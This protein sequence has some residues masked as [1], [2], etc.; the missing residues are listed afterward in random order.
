[1]FSENFDRELQKEI[2]TLAAKAYPNRIKESGMTGQI[3]AINKDKL[4]ANI[5]Y[6]CEHELLEGGF[7]RHQFKI[8]P[9]LPD[10]KLTQ[11][12]VDFILNDG[13]LPALQDTSLL[14]LPQDLSAGLAA[15][16]SNSVTD[17]EEK[18]GMLARLEALTG[19]QLT[20][21]SLTLLS[22]GLKQTPNAVQ[23][24]QSEFSDAVE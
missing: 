1:M 2:L 12:G 13:G 17:Q 8:I 14:K 16:I 7:A 21:I 18:A 23:W 24:L 9:M 6:L 10:A 15:F 20:K 3:K 19:E 22:S 11:K 5:F 4:L